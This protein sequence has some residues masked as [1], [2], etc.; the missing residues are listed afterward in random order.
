[1]SRSVDAVFR[2]TDKQG[3]SMPVV[4][5]SW[6][7]WLSSNVARGCSIDSM[8]DAMVQAGFTTEAARA[9]VHKAF[10]RDPADAAI[11]ITAASEAAL[12]KPCRKRTNTTSRPLRVAM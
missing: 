2:D 5:A 6:E 4:D 3:S 1:M 9:E 8:V 7:G 11:P 10:G 12:E